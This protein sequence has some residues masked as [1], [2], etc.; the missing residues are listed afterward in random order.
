MRSPNGFNRR[1]GQLLR[2]IIKCYIQK[3]LSVLGSQFRE[4]VRRIRKA[5]LSNYLA[6]TRKM[7]SAQIE[8]VNAIPSLVSGLMQKKQVDQG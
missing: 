8:K 3:I 4:F 1:P 6:A 2:C 5:G 7:N